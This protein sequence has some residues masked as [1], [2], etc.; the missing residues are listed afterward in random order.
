M[1]LRDT[2]FKNYKPEKIVDNSKINQE[3][4]NK[5][6]RCEARKA[7]KELSDLM[8]NVVD[9]AIDDYPDLEE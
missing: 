1:S 7:L 6:K 2:I 9:G 5:R 4:A 3:M 8:P